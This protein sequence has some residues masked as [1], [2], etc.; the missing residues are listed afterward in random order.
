MVEFEE[1]ALRTEGPSEKSTAERLFEEGKSASREDRLEEAI[2][3]YRRVVSMDPAH[4][5]AWNNLGVLLDQRGDHDVALEHFQAAVELEPENAEVL[6]NLGAALAS[7]GRYD[8]AE[9]KLRKAARI[10][11]GRTDVRANL[12]IL[13]FRR[14]LYSR[15]DQELQ[16]VCEDDPD[17]TLAHFYRG[18]ALNRLGRVDE[19]LEMLERAVHLQP[20]RARVYYLMGIL[21]D[22]KNLKREAEVMY[23][24]AKDLTDR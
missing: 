2:G 11:P 1:G 20:K 8:E 3:L 13:Y 12:G 17:H 19:A 10:D 23:R 9:I 18:E 15:S 4:L 6:T 5:R 24:K 7:Q 22:K 16:W 21:Y 14:G